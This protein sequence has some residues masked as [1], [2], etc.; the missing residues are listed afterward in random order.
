VEAA[1]GESGRRITMERLD[2]DEDGLFQ[3]VLVH[4]PEDNASLEISYEEGEAVMEQ[5]AELAKML[6]KQI[7]GQQFAQ[8]LRADARLDVMHFERMEDDAP[9]E[10]ET[11]DDIALEALNPATL[12]SVVQT[13]ATLTGGLPIDPAAGEVMI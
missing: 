2:A 4:A 6:R 5:S 10:E 13:L 12:I 11:E 3:S 1:I 7:D 9:L 8:L